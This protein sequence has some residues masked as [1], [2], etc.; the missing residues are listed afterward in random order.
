MPSRRD[1]EYDTTKQ[2]KEAGLQD[3]LAGDEVGERKLDLLVDSSGA[4]ESRVED[5]RAGQGEGEIVARTMENEE[6]RREMEGTART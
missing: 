2:E 6:R 3:L 1:P 4:E 5:V